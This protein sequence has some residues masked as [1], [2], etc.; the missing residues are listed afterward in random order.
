MSYR[1]RMRTVFARLGVDDQDV[2]GLRDAMVDVAYARTA[3]KM[4]AS[5]DDFIGIC[6]C[7]VCSERDKVA[8][9]EF[10]RASNH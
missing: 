9:E 10:R 7:Q 5:L 4:G 3:A 6:P 8:M 1:L 2:D